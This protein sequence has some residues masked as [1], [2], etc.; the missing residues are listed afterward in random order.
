MFDWI[1]SNEIQNVFRIDSE[2]Y[3]GMARIRSDR[4]PFQNFR[5][6][7]NIYVKFSR[8]DRI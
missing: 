6:E 8:L 4:I 2:T 3:F 7:N 1:A 5:Q